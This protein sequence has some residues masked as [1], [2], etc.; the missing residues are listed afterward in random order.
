[1]DEPH[2]HL[3]I[4]RSAEYGSRIGPVAFAAGAGGFLVWLIS[5]DAAPSVGAVGWLVG[6]CGMMVALSAALASSVGL[7]SPDGRSQA[8][9]G[10]MMSALGILIP[11]ALAF[12]VIS[13]VW[14]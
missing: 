2:V 4:R 1:M 13:F 5:L 14:N 6:L 11:A 7:L 3:F 9:R 8:A 10:L 12:F